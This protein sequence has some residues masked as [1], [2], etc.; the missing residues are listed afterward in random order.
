[1]SEERAK[2]VRQLQQKVAAGRQVPSQFGRHRRH[3]SVER[4]LCMLTHS[5]LEALGRAAWVFSWSAE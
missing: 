4:H 5:R 3:L 1:M 2:L